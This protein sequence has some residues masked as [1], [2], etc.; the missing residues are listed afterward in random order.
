MIGGDLKTRKNE[1]GE[2]LLRRLLDDEQ[3]RPLI[4][5]HPISKRLAELVGR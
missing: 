2:Y 4:L 3:A 1:W 5:G